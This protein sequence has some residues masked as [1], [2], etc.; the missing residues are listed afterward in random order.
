MKVCAAQFEVTR[1]V[2]R[3]PIAMLINTGLTGLT[4]Q[5]KQSCDAKCP[6]YIREPRYTADGGQSAFTLSPAAG[7]ALRER[8]IDLSL[9][10]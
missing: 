3:S 9:S 5:L 2:T 1:P 4:E 6:Y 8:H 7:L 10:G